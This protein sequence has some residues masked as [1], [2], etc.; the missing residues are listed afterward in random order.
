MTAT[1]DLAVS[2]DR[3]SRGLGSFAT[4]PSL[5]LAARRLLIAVPVLWGVSALTFLVMSVLPGNAAQQ[6]LGVQATPEQ[7]HKLTVEL[8][9][10]KPA[11]VR[12]GS[13]LGGVLTGNLGNSLASGQPVTTIIGQ[14]LPVTVELVLYALLISLVLAVPV[15]LLAARRPGG[16]ADR[17]SMGLSMAGLSMANYVLALV[18]VIVLAVYVP[19]FPAIGFV[20]LAD[21]VGGNLRSLTL[22]A[23]A[24]G[25]PLACFYTRLL[26]ADIADQ[27]QEDYVVTARAKGVG[28]WQ[29]LVRHA[30]RNSLFGL[31]TI[32][33]FNLGTLI[34][35]TVI[36][37][38][39]FSLPGIG[40]AF[41]QAINNRDV[42]LIE[43]VVLVLATAV[44]L[45]NLLTDVLYA[46][47]DPRIRYGQRPD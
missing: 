6:I 18:L 36:I 40:Q 21:N 28:P 1:A 12:Y 2:T 15:A 47:L 11:P 22:P 7:V 30:L 43:A 23:L 27:M 38:Q 9:L 3:L 19:V 8:G 45:A 10:D 35:A 5:R 41:I 16:L 13:W 25:F 24:I 37:E 17:L 20:P 14:R 33:G 32:V 29:V 39:I 4:S 42:P 31:L 44:V 26:R 34:G 46:V